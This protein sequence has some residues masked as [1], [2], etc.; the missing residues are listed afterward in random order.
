GTFAQLRYERRSEDLFGRREIERSLLNAV[1]ERL[2]R[3]HTNLCDI[4]AMPYGTH[5]P[6]RREE[7][8]HWLGLGELQEGA[9]LLPGPLFG[10][11]RAL[12]RHKVVERAVECRLP[13][14]RRQ[15]RWRR[16][17]KVG[18]QRLNE[19][20]VRERVH[21]EDRMIDQRIVERVTVRLVFKK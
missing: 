7:E 13:F 20:I 19:H 14:L 15:V 8:I 10:G 18:K 6:I 4:V 2:N 9:E 5:G 21:E 3:R 1:S 11:Q 12:A 17:A 16:Q